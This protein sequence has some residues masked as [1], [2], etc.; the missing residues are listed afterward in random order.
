AAE[1]SLLVTIQEGAIG[2][3]GTAV[4]H[5]LAE[6]DALSQLSVRSMV[7]PDRFIAHNSVAAMYAEAGLD[8]PA[9]AR[10]VLDALGRGQDAARP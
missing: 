5:T 4:L 9:I 6:H 7:L 1:H 2:G 8:A 3:F 10:R